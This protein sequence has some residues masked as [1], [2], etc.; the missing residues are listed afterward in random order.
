MMKKKNIAA[1]WF[2]ARDTTLLCSYFYSLQWHSWMG[3]RIC[4]SSSRVTSS[5]CVAEL[6]IDV[7]V[8]ASLMVFLCCREM[9]FLFTCLMQYSH[10]ATNMYSMAHHR[11]SMV[12]ILCGRSGVALDMAASLESVSLSLP[13]TSS[14]VWELRR[15]FLSREVC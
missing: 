7:L 6:L 9:S 14:P 12:V 15:C 2:F 13:Y 11:L 10:D 3:W 4:G 8:K 5:T 1:P